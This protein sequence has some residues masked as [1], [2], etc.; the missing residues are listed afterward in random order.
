MRA[1]WRLRARVGSKPRVELC[2][3]V[4]VCFIVE[5]GIDRIGDW[6]SLLRLL[7]LGYQRGQTAEGGGEAEEGGGRGG[8]GA[9]GAKAPAP[10]VGKP[11]VAAAVEV[12][13]AP[14]LFLPGQGGKPAVLPQSCC[15][16]NVGGGWGLCLGCRWPS[17]TCPPG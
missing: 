1:P 12:L 4:C 16:P 3:C 9:E 8:R 2:V 6:G 10:Q 7:P 5:S 15:A 17:S 13:A 11:P 14:A